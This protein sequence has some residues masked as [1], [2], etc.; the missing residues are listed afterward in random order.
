MVQPES[1]KDARQ[2]SIGYDA[3]DRSFPEYRHAQEDRLF[4]A[5][6]DPTLRD[7]KS[8]DN[9]A[10]ARSEEELQTFESSRV[11]SIDRSRSHPFGKQHNRG[12][13]RLSDARV[14]QYDSSRAVERPEEHYPTA[15]GQAPV[16]YGLPPLTRD[17]AVDEAGENK[18]ERKLN[19]LDLVSQLRDRDI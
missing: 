10:M 15:A 2:R 17:N 13:T 8:K 12:S 3:E 11:F 6:G 18:A 4:R 9:E 5:P 7:S 1:S 16:A 14:T 19:L